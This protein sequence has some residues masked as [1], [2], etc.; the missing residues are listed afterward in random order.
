MNQSIIAREIRGEKSLTVKKIFSLIFQYNLL[1]C[2]QINGGSVNGW[3]YIFAD[4]CGVS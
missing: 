2:F 1:T 4:A 3:L